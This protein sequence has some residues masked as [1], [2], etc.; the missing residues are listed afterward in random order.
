MTNVASS[1]L[2]T[3]KRADPCAKARFAAVR[4]MKSTARRFIGHLICMNA[5]SGQNTRGA[6]PQ[7]AVD[8]QCDARY[9]R[10]RIGS[11][12]QRRVRNLV[13]G[14]HSPERAVL[15]EARARCIGHQ[16]A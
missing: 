16:P 4:T 15:L 14:G 1:L 2:R 7:T 12:I 3:S 5:L 10:R 11:E 8:D 13:D 9:E 6:Q